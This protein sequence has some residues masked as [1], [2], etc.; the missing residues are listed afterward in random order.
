[1]TRTEQAA[2]W[3]PT[4]EIAQAAGHR[5]M[6]PM[7]AIREKCLD[8]CSGQPSEVR[9]CESVKCSLWPFRSGSHPYTSAKMKNP[10][11]QADFQE[12]GPAEGA[13]SPSPVKSNP[14]KGSEN[15]R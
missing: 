4:A 13:A 5:K 9:L 2:V 15:E 7:K 8:C 12:E 10:L 3:P 14:H 1:M 6:S 11:L